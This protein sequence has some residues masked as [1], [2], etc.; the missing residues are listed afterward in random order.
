MLF[1][2]ELSMAHA[3]ENRRPAGFHHAA[4]TADQGKSYS[5]DGRADYYTGPSTTTLLWAKLNNPFV[6]A[7]L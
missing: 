7:I 6:K 2:P 4:L 5:P 3:K 1:G